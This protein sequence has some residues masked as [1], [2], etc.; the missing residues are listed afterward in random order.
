MNTPALP[1]PELLHVE[2][3]GAEVYI[4]I[5]E[6]LERLCTMSRPGEAQ[7]LKD[8]QMIVRAC[9]SHAA[10]VEALKGLLKFTDELC[11]DVH[12]SLHY[13]SAEKA[14]AALKEVA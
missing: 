8:A 3:D 5:S 4:T 11:E 10:L 9:N 13:P 6:G 1:P 7:R 2:R 12:V 14:R